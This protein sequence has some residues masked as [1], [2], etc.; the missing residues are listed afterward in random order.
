VTN[1]QLSIH[2]FLQL[3][4]ILAATRA[5]GAVA[6]KLGQPQVV[7]EMIAGVLL[8][9]SL[10]GLI[11]PD[12]MRLLFP[13]QAMPV[14]YCAAQL[15]LVLYMFV[16]GLELRVDLI[17]KKAGGALGISLAGIIV[18]FALGV[19][20]SRVLLSRGGFFSE[21]ADGF[22]AALFMGAAMSI[23]AFPMLARIIY[24]RG[25]TGTIVG[26]L[27]LAAGA[28]DDAIAW[29]LLAVVTASFGGQ[30]SI[31]LWAIGGG[32]GYA[33]LTLGGLRRVLTFLDREA[34]RDGQLSSLSFVFVLMLLMIAA[35]FTDWVGIYAV[36]GA[37]I[38]GV[39]M[40]RGP[41]SQDLQRK[42]EPLTTHLLL[43]LFFVYSGL[44]TQIG[45]VNTPAL[46]AVAV[47]VL[48][49]A[50]FGKGVACWAAAR[51]AGQPQRQSIAI[52]ALM[53]ARGLMELILLNIGL[54]QGLITPVLFSIMVFMAVVTTLMATPIFEWV[55]RGGDLR[56]FEPAADRDS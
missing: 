40:P 33:L 29:C 25:L 34:R 50:C 54:E 14:L 46:L 26:T 38:L 41:V 16:V 44:N 15:G 21:K 51:I 28:T 30:W 18:P 39:A 37:F 9:P 11:A 19:L 32:I 24:E 1:F 47:V 55:A 22:E 8:G 45:L 56:Q 36:F 12:V 31:A 3:A 20:L 49:A 42:I 23:T 6:R 7:G 5:V 43:P 13:A 48:L 53:N 4:A 35:W 17:V 52:G 27:S 2:V 10:L